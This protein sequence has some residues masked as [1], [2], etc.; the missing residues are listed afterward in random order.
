[1]SPSRPID[2]VSTG[3]VEARLEG[4]TV[5]ELPFERRFVSLDEFGVELAAGTVVARDD[6]RHRFLRLH[7]SRDAH[8][9]LVARA[10]P[11]ASG[12]VV[13]LDPARADCLGRRRLA[14]PRLAQEV[15][16]KPPEEDLLE[17][18]PLPVVAALV[19]VENERPRRPLLVVRIA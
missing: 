10:E 17:R 5:A 2:R 8:D 11:P 6:A 7:R 12:R 13:D 3:V 15:A 19:D 16:A 4:A 18:R 9:G 14:H 1:S